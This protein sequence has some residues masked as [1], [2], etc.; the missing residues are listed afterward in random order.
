M[1]PASPNSAYD[2]NTPPPN[3]QG[4]IPYQSRSSPPRLDEVSYGGTNNVIL[5]SSNSLRRRPTNKSQTDLSDSSSLRRATPE[6]RDMQP[7]PPVPTNPY[8]RRP[9]QDSQRPNQQ[10]ND[11]RSPQQ[12]G[13]DNRPQ[14]QFN[15]SINSARK[16][17]L[18]SAS[19]NQ[20]ERE[21]REEKAALDRSVSLGDNRSD[22]DR[23][24]EPPS[25]ASTLANAAPLATK[26]GVI[27]PNKSMM[28]EEDP[29]E[30]PF[31]NPPPES[32]LEEEEEVLESE[33]ETS[34]APQA[35]NLSQSQGGGGGMGGFGGLAGLAGKFIATDRDR[36]D[37]GEKEASAKSDNEYFD[38]VS[39][40]RASVAS[41]R[42]N[43]VPLSRNASRNGRDR[44][45][46]E[47]ER[48][49]EELKKE[50]E[51]KIATLMKRAQ[52]GDEKVKGLEEDLENQREVS[53][54]L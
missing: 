32:E 1:T 19:E 10:F 29:I 11:G 2:E 42:S 31:D 4:P 7:N 45:G 26:A 9:S 44:E 5:N 22:R 35:E 37:R 21:K 38:K 12:Y 51:Y 34:P 40:G 15:S 49:K 18:R 20:R 53:L 50:Y 6:D 41:D 43:G 47:R 3:N 33:Y 17:P 36:D 30:V 48:E 25:I 52:V 39:F 24:R 14:Q 23:D 8:T 54:L 46:G 27:I 16:P 13:E 28:A